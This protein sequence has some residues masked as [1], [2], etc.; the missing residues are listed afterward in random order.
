[1]DWLAL[2]PIAGLVMLFIDG[3]I[4]FWGG[5]LLLV[6]AFTDTPMPTTTPTQVNQ[7]VNQTQDGGDTTEWN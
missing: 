4:G 1:M 7:P 6:L 3:T 5:A 2:L